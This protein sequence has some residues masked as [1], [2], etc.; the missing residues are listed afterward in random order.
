MSFV[1]G[2]SQISSIQ[3]SLSQ[4]QI[5]TQ[6]CDKISSLSESISHKDSKCHLLSYRFILVRCMFIVL[7]W[8][9]I[10]MLLRLLSLGVIVSVGWGVSYVL[11]VAWCWRCSCSGRGR[12]SLGL[13]G[14]WYCMTFIR[15]L[16]LLWYRGLVVLPALCMGVRRCPF[17][18]TQPNC[19]WSRSCILFWLTSL[20]CPT[21]HL[22]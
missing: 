1:S 22:A 18:Y 20:Y 21:T 9:C 5:D 11:S 4:L 16:N 15:G 8:F 17:H 12:L 14:R 19:P 2:P 6:S 3:L 7:I 13:L 10:F